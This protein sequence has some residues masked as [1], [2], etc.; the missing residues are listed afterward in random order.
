MIILYLC[1]Y[2]LYEKHLKI[3][4][5][6]IYVLPSIYIYE[7]IECKVAGVNPVWEVVILGNELTMV[8]IIYLK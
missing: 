4:L 7:N 5:L 2:G 3:Y 8:D 6:Y 1:I